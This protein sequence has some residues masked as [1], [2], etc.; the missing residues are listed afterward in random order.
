MDQPTPPPHLTAHKDHILTTL[1]FREARRADL[2]Y[3]VALLADDRLGRARENADLPLHPDYGAAFDTI[4]AAPDNRLIVAEHR[5]AVVAFCQFIVIPYLS[6]RGAPRAE[7]ESVHVRS[8]MRGQGIGAALM[9]HVIAL[10]RSSGCGM[11]QLT[12]DRTREDARRF[13][14]RLGFEASHIGMKMR[15]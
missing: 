3:L 5:S 13:Y 8:D 12:S 4:A 14:E 11:L 2:P 15:L 10:A 9:T 6:R 7:V 1:L